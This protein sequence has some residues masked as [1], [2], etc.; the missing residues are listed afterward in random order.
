MIFSFNDATF[1]PRKVSSAQKNT[2]NGYDFKN[3]RYKSLDLVRL[4]SSERLMLYSDVVNAPITGDR[5]KRIVEDFEKNSLPSF[6]DYFGKLPID[7]FEIVFYDIKDNYGGAIKDY[8][9]GYFDSQL[10]DN[11]KRIFIDTY[12]TLIY[13]SDKEVSG[14][15][16]HE[17]QHLVHYRYDR[18]EESW[19]NEGMSEISTYICGGENAYHVEEFVSY[20]YINL[21]EWN[22]TIKDYG[23]VYLF[24]RYLIYRKGGEVIRKILKNSENGVTGISDVMGYDSFINF[25]SEF[26]AALTLNDS[27]DLKYDMMGLDFELLPIDIT[28]GHKFERKINLKPFSFVVVDHYPDING[29][30][31]ILIDEVDEDILVKA[32]LYQ[33]GRLSEVLEIEKGSPTMPEG[34]FDKVRYIFIN[35]NSRQKESKIKVQ[36]LIPEINVLSNPYFSNNRFFAVKGKKLNKVLLKGDSLRFFEC[37]IGNDFYVFSADIDVMGENS[38]MFEFFYDDRLYSGEMIFQGGSL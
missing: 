17:L 4:Y 13:E 18:D 1:V 21:T 15:I 20:P 23:K 9:A 7:H 11:N 3:D 5:M 26:S 28:K 29:R 24:F 2:I 6:E 33:K 16:A 12:P 19:V 32:A 10:S 14:I 27:G 35:A 22:E 38:L 8:Y 36:S 37:D 25:F 31:N 34:S 30:Y